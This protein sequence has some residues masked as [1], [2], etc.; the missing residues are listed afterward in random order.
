MSFD[1]KQNEYKHKHVQRNKNIDT[2][3]SWMTCSLSLSL[4]LAKG[5]E[6]RF[7]LGSCELCLKIFEPPKKLNWKIPL[8]IAY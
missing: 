7:N 4:A 1:Y 3:T 6:K 5:T 2:Y 8:E